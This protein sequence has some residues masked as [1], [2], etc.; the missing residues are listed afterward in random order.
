MSWE[1]VILG[2]PHIARQCGTLST[3]PAE[4]YRFR[5]QEGGFNF[6][7]NGHQWGWR[8]DGSDF[9]KMRRERDSLKQQLGRL[10]DEAAET[11]RE[12]ERAEQ[13]AKRLRKRA[14]AGT[15][16][17]CKRSFSHMAEHIKRRHPSFI[18]EQGV[19]VVTIADRKRA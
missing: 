3:T 10:A 13:T 12:L 16:P 4:V 8:R 14:A 9:E 19:N 15:C 7:P 6:C 5:R 11:R 18:A 17:C 2:Q 1:V